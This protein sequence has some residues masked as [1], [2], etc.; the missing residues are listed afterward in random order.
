MAL[1]I[2]CD[3]CGLTVECSTDH[4]SG[5]NEID[6]SSKTGG[7]TNPATT[8]ALSVPAK[9]CEMPPGKPDDVCLT[10]C[11]G[12]SVCGVVC[13]FDIGGYTSALTDLIPLVDRPLA[14]RLCLRSITLGR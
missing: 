4:D 10:I 5:Y 2:T 13:L 9:L 7:F 1:S 14:D 11:P 3:D 6:G 12:L 8:A